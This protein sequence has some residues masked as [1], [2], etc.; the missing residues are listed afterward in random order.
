MENEKLATELLHEVKAS[1]IRWFY[2]FLIMCVIEICTIAGFLWYIS[3][4]TDEISVESTEGNANYIGNDL[5]GELNNGK[6]NSQ[7]TP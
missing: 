6:D 5:N 7:E 4:P 1:A 2:A 3:L